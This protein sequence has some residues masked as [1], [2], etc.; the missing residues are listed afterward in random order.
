M[1]RVL[2]YTDTSQIGGAELQMFLLA[3]FLNKEKITPLL[4]C[5]N[6]PKLDEWCSKFQNENIRVIRL[7]VKGKH[8]PKHYTQLRKIIRE[9]GI[10]ILHAHV[11]NPASCRY[12]YMQKIPVITTE[13][14]PFAINSI[15]NLFKKYAIKKTKRIITV[16]KNNADLLKKLYP[17]QSKKIEVIPNGLDLTWWDSQLLR[18]NEHDI[19]EVKRKTFNAMEDTLIITSIAELHSRKGLK[20]LISTMPKITEKYPNV[21]LVII[22]D[23]KEKDALQRLINR[24]KISNHVELLGRKKE[25]PKL[26][27]AS[28]IF[29]LPSNREAFGMVNLE[30]MATPLPIVA[31]KVGGIPEIIK[32]NK[33]GILV[34]AK[35]TK[36][37][38]QALEKLIAS[39]SLREKMALAGRKHLEKT[40]SALK[41][42]QQYEKIY[43]KLK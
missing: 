13:H 8:D 31:T 41:M 4:A 33:T 43:T 34:E 26:L 18:F 19:E 25:I 11:W 2:L 35:N 6:S 32:H 16:S 42:A 9:D 17:N 37:I 27:K 24:L 36:S 30:A 38:R 5:S 29:V 12:A 23:G 21:K 3:K 40:F 28:N 22:G 20:Y 14:D 10:D 1:K 7:N 39:E 15:K